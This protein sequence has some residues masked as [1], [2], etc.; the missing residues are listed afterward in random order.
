MACN[1]SIPFASPDF[2]CIMEPMRDPIWK[3]IADHLHSPMAI[4]G[5]HLRGGPRKIE[6]NRDLTTFL[7]CPSIGAL[8]LGQSAF[9]AAGVALHLGFETVGLVGVDITPDRFNNEAH[10]REVQEAY[11]R[12]NE[13]AENMGRKLI[14]LNPESHLSTVPFGSWSDIRPKHRE[15]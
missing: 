15:S 7:D 8:R 14:N 6:F 13:T 9:W 2:A 10:L 12:L 3:Q 11:R 1:R 4:F 5:H